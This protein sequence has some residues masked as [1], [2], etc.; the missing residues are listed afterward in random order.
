MHLIGKNQENF[1]HKKFRPTDPISKM[2]PFWP[3]F[4]FSELNPDHFWDFRFSKFRFFKNVKKWPKN[5]FSKKCVF[6][7]SVCENGK[8]DLHI[9]PQLFFSSNGARKL[10]KNIAR[11][12][13]KVSRIRPKKNAKIDFCQKITRPKKNVS[14]KCSKFFL[15]HSKTRLKRCKKRRSKKQF[16][17]K[18]FF[19]K[20]FSKFF[21]KSGVRVSGLSSENQKVGQNGVIFEMG[22]I[23]KT[24][25][26]QKFSWFLCSK[27]IYFR[28][29]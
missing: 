21:F 24:V 28:A 16:F 1:S 4:W 8:V 25:W 19:P 27:C 13:R 7:G 14:Q 26:R 3:T 18:N 11:S 20:I 2:T 9:A 22:P 5:F 29:I 15:E 23:G 10:Y 6:L 17:S 12:Q